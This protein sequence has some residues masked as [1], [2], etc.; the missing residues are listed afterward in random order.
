[1]SLSVC[2]VTSGR[3]T[4]TRTLRS[5]AVQLQN[6]DD[7]VLVIGN[8]RWIQEQAESFGFRYIEMGPFGDWGQRER[9]AA[10][11]YATRSHLLWND[12][13]DFYMT[14][15]FDA[16][17]EEIEQHPNS[18]LMFKM[19]A[20]GGPLIWVDRSVRCGNVSGQQFVV[21][22]KTNYLGEWAVRHDGDF[23]FVESTLRLYPSD[24]L[25]WNDTTIVG[26]R[27]QGVARM[28]Q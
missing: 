25:V 19:I 9:Q 27:D 15:A 10:M 14:G 12:D 5:A 2:I 26:C 22:N 17:R 24:S 11:Q 3:K 8:G 20:P 21:P 18:P 13:D 1:M 7:E 4:L 28:A 6:D 23:L 16:I